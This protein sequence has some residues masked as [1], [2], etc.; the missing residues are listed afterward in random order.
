MTSMGITARG[1]KIKMPALQLPSRIQPSAGSSQTRPR[2][3]KA[4]ANA[5]VIIPRRERRIQGESQAMDP[6]ATGDALIPP[7]TG[8]DPPSPPEP[9]QASVLF[10]EESARRHALKGRG[11]LRTGCAELDGAL[12]LGGFERG[13]VVGVSA[14][15]E[16][17]AVTVSR[18]SSPEGS[19]RAGRI[20]PLLR[21][22]EFLTRHADG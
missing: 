2:Q 6:N 22:T 3:W 4:A 16:D 7:L 14:E 12:L 1:V 5:C 17:F 11:T 20:D 18:L 8:A 19:G 10:A 9:V 13:C 15:E 21:E